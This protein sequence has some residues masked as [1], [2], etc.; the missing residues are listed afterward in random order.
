MQLISDLCRGIVVETKLHTFVTGNILYC[1]YVEDPYSRST[2]INSLIDLA[3]AVPILNIFAGITRIV[4][5]SLHIIVQSLALVFT[6]DRRYIV[7]I[8]KGGC[9]ILKGLIQATPFVGHKFTRFWFDNGYWWMIKIYN[10]D[11][12]DYFDED[13]NYW[14]DFRISRP[15]AY[16]VC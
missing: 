13:Q 16:F 5:A 3:A 1:D 6:F 9:E 14:K 11:K 4:L 10:P 15:T 2:R 12:P 7:H 8:A